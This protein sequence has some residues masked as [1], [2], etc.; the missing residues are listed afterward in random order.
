MTSTKNMLAASTCF[1]RLFHDRSCS[2]R[3]MKRKEEK[4]TRVVPINKTSDHFLSTEE[5]SASRALAQF[6]T[7]ES[8][9]FRPNDT[10]ESKYE[11][12]YPRLYE[13]EVI[14]QFWNKNRKNMAHQNNWL[15]KANRHVD[16]NVLSSLHY[17]VTL[18]MRN[19]LSVWLHHAK[20]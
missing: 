2:N 15:S 4:R 11:W 14:C 12:S 10:L 17:F 8:F 18:P 7:F 6:D 16:V 1:F 13:E 20:F 19:L 3:T 9:L 5:I